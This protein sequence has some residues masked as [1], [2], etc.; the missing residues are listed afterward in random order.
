MEATEVDPRAVE[1]TVS[2]GEVLTNSEDSAEGLE[3]A[4]SGFMGLEV[5]ADLDIMGLEDFQVRNE[6]K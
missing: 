3:V 4:D 6:K 2:S 1:N 5:I